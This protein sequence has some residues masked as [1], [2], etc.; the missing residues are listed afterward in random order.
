MGK[1]IESSAPAASKGGQNRK[2]RH[3][4]RTTA[5][6]PLVKLNTRRN[7]TLT[8]KSHASLTEQADRKFRLRIEIIVNFNKHSFGMSQHLR[9]STQDEL[10]DAIDI[11]L[12]EIGPR[13]VKETNRLT[14]TN[15]HALVL[16]SAILDTQRGDHNR[17]GQLFFMCSVI[18]ASCP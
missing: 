2:E 13:N 18:P 4:L 15:A 10:L 8:H 11:N 14:H 3:R 7:I 5:D 1:I 12:D 17:S 6:P 9:T 16:W